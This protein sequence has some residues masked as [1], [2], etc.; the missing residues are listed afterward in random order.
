MFLDVHQPWR[1]VKVAKHR[2]ACDFALCMS[3]LADT[4]YP[5]ADLIRLVMDNSLH[6]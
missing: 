2:T 6:A 1:H 5:D 3:D 4:H